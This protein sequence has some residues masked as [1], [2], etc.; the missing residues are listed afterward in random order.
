MNIN[1]VKMKKPILRFFSVLLLL[2]LGAGMASAARGDIN[3]DGIV[4]VTDVNMVIDMVLGKADL[5]YDTADLD[6]NSVIDVTDVS[7]LIDIVLGKATVQTF[8][9]NG[10]TFTMV[11]VEGGTFMMGASDD[12]TEADNDEKPAHQVTLSDY[13]IAVTEVTQELW[14]AVMDSNPSR[15]T[16]DLQRPVENVSWNDCQTF[17][18]KLNRLTGKTFRLPTE[19]E[20]EFAARGGNQS[21]GYKYAGSNIIGDVVWYEMNANFVGTSSPDYGTHPVGTKAPNELGLYDMCG[22]AYEWCYDWYGS[23]S[24]SEQTDPKGASSG[25]GRVGRGGSWRNYAGYCRVLFRNSFV[26][27]YKSDNLGFRLAL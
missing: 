7:I 12:D 6:G 25:N 14:E 19:A 4:D 18:K 3:G 11:E 13:S 24:S 22:N 15:F 17:I 8:T 27:T 2:V 1:H 23:Y 21:Q 5:N 20:W 10:V 9:V 26:P 16:G